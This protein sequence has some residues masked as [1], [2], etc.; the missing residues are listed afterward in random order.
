[1]LNAG[2]AM[3]CSD[4]VIHYCSLRLVDLRNLAASSLRANSRMGGAIESHHAYRERLE[5]DVLKVLRQ[6]SLALCR[7]HETD[8]LVGLKSWAAS[9]FYT[10]FEQGSQLSQ[11]VYDS[12]KHLSWMS[13]LIFQSQGQYEKA[14]AHYSHLLQS[15]EA[16]TSMKSDGIQYIIERVI[17]CYTSLSD[18]K[19]LES[20]LAELQVLRAVHAGKPYSGA[21]TTAG[22][23]LNAIH[24]MA[25]FDEGDFHSA[26]GYLDLTPKS[27]S[28]LS[29]D[30]KVAI[31][32]SEVMLLRAMLQSDSKSDRVREELDKAKLMLGEALSVVPLNGL[33]EAAHCAGQLHCIFAFE[34]ASGRTC[35]NEPNKS[36]MTMDSLLKVLHDP[37]DRLHQDCSMWL[38]IFKVYRHT[39][40]SSLSTLLLCQKL[41]S[42]ARKQSNFMLASRLNHYLL[43]HPLNSSDDMDK[44]ILELNIKYEGA[45]LKHEEGN[46]EEALS[47]LWS[48]VRPS[49]LSTVS[50]SSDIGTSLS[51]VAKA[52]LKL[53]TWMEQKN[54]THNLNTF[55]QKVIKDLSDFD[56]FQN[57]AGKLLSGDSF[58]VST[59]NCYT[60]AQEMIGTARKISCQLCPSMGKAW[61]AYASWCFTHANYS[62]SGTDLNLLNSISPVLQSELSPDR[63]HLT[64]NEKSEVEEII[65]S[66][67]AENSANHVGHDYPSTTGCYSYAQEN[68]ITSLIEQ[69]A[70]L[71]ETAAGAPG[72]EAREGEDPLRY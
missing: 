39:Q 70:C 67:C 41:A 24:A 33:T 56:G 52:C 23:E 31:E 72:S 49:I 48:L 10:L 50:G 64:N 45:L 28:E 14:A 21:L 4:A 58:L 1:M 8:A 20:W 44:E 37:I 47:D 25:C 43:N 32:R 29:L 55:I 2:L 7:C 22:N 54:S 71:I 68:S 6:A 27:S 35:Q 65:R 62:V 13:G 19:C 69:A 15:E 30:P 26:W 3:H 16:L 60:L 57:G 12:T 18:W 38:K 59:S 53:S 9:T 63:Y 40:P 17:E 11:A 42:L 51:L 46:D 5:A 61:I 66:I 36:Q 34:E